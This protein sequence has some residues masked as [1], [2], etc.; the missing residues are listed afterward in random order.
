MVFRRKSA[1]WSLFSVQM[2][3]PLTVTLPALGRR[4]PEIMLSSVVLPLPEGPTMNS[5][6]PK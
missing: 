6:S 3:A 5:I 4:M 2:S 1:S